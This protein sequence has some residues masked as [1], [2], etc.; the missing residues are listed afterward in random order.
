MTRTNIYNIINTT[1]E[2]REEDAIRAIRNKK[3]RSVFVEMDGQSIMC[4]RISNYR[5]EV[6]IR[7]E[8]AKG[9]I[10]RKT[11]MDSYELEEWVG[12]FTA[13]PCKIRVA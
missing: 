13:G 6:E 12:I 10:K 5:W 4:T 8:M 11:E 2:T 7:T 3:N 9:T 1:Y